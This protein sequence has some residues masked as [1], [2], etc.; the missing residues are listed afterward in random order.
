MG[1]VP[2][3]ARRRGPTPPGAPTGLA[4]VGG[5]GSVDIDWADNLEPAL[6]GYTVSRAAAAG[7]PFAALNGTL[8]SASAFSDATVAAGTTY[9]YRVT[10][11]DLSGNESSA[12]ATASA[13][14]SGGGP[15]GT[16]VWINEFHYDNDGTDVNEFVEV[17]GT[18]GTSLAGW[19]VVGYNGTGGAS[20]A[21]VNLSG[22]LPNQ[23]AG[24]GTASFA[25]AGMQNG[26]PDGLALIDGSGQVVQ[27]LSYEGSFTAVGAAANGLVATDV[28][29]S[30]GTTSPV[31]WT[32]QLTGSGS[33]Y[34]AFAWQAPAAGTAGLVNSGQ[35]FT[36]GVPNVA[37]TADAGGP[38]AGQTGAA[39]AFSSAGSS[40]SDGTL[41]GWS[42]TGDGAIARCEP[43]TPTPPPV[44]PSP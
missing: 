12:S 7:G 31:G 26:S 38:Y 15:G 2:F 42:W 16:V 25:F 41:T 27:F 32:L 29:V 28:G 37:P 36:G 44:T 19:S 18:A 39:I 33:T 34:A 9:W 23:Q 5:P 22:S 6:A 1:R 3:R 11:T 14:T 30:E 20:Y 35:S 8:L 10:A 17:A 4:A 21:T 24:F 13:T 43:H 40:D